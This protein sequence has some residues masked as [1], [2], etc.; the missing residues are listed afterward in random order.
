MI[1]LLLAEDHLLV[2]A[3]LAHLINS[4][5]GIH[6]VA[7]GA[8]GH[9][10]LDA[11]RIH[12][13]DVALIDAALLPVQDWDLIHQLKTMRPGI[14]ILVTSSYR[15]DRYVERLM[16]AGACGF[17]HKNAAVNELETAIHH[18]AAHR[19]V[20][21]PGIDISGLAATEQAPSPVPALTRRQQE[22]L[23]LIVDGCRSRTIAEQLDL[24]VKTVEAHRRE[25]MRRV[26]KQNSAGLVKEAIRL[27]L[28]PFPT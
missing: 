28:V 11:A 2:R 18:A 24:S 17:V 10:I 23:K 15:S 14:N 19:R 4:F 6:V 13:V 3:A 26:G 22:I 12:P 25:I 5:Q 8:Y 27:G 21:Y 16:E 7:E 9:E 20:L 1:N